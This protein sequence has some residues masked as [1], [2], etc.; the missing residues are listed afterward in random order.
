VADLDDYDWAL[1]PL[2][3]PIDVDMRTQGDEW[4]SYLFRRLA[5]TT[6]STGYRARLESP[7]GYL[8]TPSEGALVSSLLVAQSADRRPI[9]HVVGYGAPLDEDLR[10]WADAIIYAGNQVGRTQKFSWLAVVGEDPDS[11]I[12]SPLQLTGSSSV[13]GITLLPNDTAYMEFREGNSL[14][15]A[16]GART[17]LIL[18]RGVAKGYDAWVATRQASADLKLLCS[19]LSLAS[20]RTWV[21]REG[22]NCLGQ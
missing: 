21:L 11:N 5:E 20:G 4:I 18:A 10:R 6:S 1:N 17:F 2:Q 14:S 16:S 8:Y 3:E 9:C 19:M 15:S 13:G 12:S 7:F 22:P